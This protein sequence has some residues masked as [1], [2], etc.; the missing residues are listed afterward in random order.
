M[1][2]LIQR[3][4]CTLTVVLYFTCLANVSAIDLSN[5][6]GND[7][8]GLP[9]RGRCTCLEQ[10]FHGKLW[11]DTAISNELVQGVCQS[12]PYPDMNKFTFQSLTKFIGAH[13]DSL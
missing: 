9:V 10:N 6:R 8:R 7:I 3:A 11:R 13:D 12:G 5:Y 1:I 4:I 2:S